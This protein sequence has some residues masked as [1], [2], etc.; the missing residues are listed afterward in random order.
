MTA[1]AAAAFGVLVLFADDNA[2]AQ[3]ATSDKAAASVTDEKGNMHIPP[4]YRTTYE[5]LGTWSVAG[6]A[7][8]GAKQLHVVYTSP[9][10]IEAFRKTGHFPEGAVLVKEVY[11]ATTKDMT[12]GT[13]SREDKL[14][15]WFLM[16][17]DTKNDYAGNK[18]WG[19]GWGWSWFDAGN[20][21]K[22]TSTDY[23]SD[24]QSCHVPA[25]STDW[26]Y[27]FGYPPLKQ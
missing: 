1:A 10:T 4:D 17:R 13:V 23:K 9:G 6:D 14:V 26:I 3:S 16:V 5:F 20:A 12:T 15:G 11:E 22:T 25:R 2:V 19:D 7:G 27:T 24:C 8:Q 21:N 18:L